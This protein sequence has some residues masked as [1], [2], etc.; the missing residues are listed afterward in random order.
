MSTNVTW[1][2]VSYSIP[3]SGEVNWPSLSSFLI[4]LGTSAAIAEEM[5]QAIRVATTTPVTVSNTTDCIV[6]S[7][8]GT[9]GA[10]A[11]TL[12][13]GVDGRIY[14]IGDQKGDAGTNNITITPNGAETINGSATY[15]IS[16]NSGVVALAYSLTNTRWNVVARFTAGAFMTNPMTTTGDTI[17]SS[18]GSTP[19]RLGIGATSTV[20]VS[21]GTAPS[22]ALLVD[23]NVSGSAAIA[24][25]KIVAATNAVAG[26]VTTATQTFGGLKTFIRT[27][28][29]TGAAD[30]NQ[31]AITGNATQTSVIALVEKSDAT[32]LLQVTNTDGTAIRGTTLASNVSAGFVGELMTVSRVKSAA[33]SLTTN[34]T[35]NVTASPLA[36]T[37]G[38]WDIEGSIVFIPG[39]T[40]SVTSLIASTT[41]TSATLPADDTYGV[42]TAGEIRMAYSTAPNVMGGEVTLSI[43]RLRVSISTTTSYYLIARPTFT[44]STLTG[45]GQLTARR[46][47]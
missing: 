36:L 10:V 43:P 21:T 39:A 22:W 7:N 40:T 14:F 30:E 34:T 25:S 31:L 32:P 42:G 5:K 29:V 19:A 6:L 11:V 3:A 13:A 41:L 4:A 47:R 26:V 16:E 23:A 35:T 20:N 12:P 27:L 9:P 45:A 8:L 15:V 17:Y 46:V 1:N 33:V 2:G 38:D 24:G 18:S 44:I 28:R 37:A